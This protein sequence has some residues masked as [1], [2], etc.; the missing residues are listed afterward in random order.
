MMQ[1]SLNTTYDMCIKCNTCVVN[2]PVSKLSIDFAGPKHLGVEL[3]R[4]TEN[5]E[6]IYDPSIKICTLCGNCDTYCPEQVD[7]TKM[8]INSKANITNYYGLKFR[9]RLLS[10]AELIG[11][12]S[13]LFASIVNV[14]LG[15]SIIRKVMD[16]VLHIEQKRIFPKYKFSN[17]RRR[18][19]KKSSYTKRKVVYF[20]GCYTNYNAPEVADAFIEVMKLNNIE[21]II[22]KQKCCGIPSL[23]NG[24]IKKAEKY[25]QYNIN[26]FLK[27]VRKGYD[28]VITCSSCSLAFK[29]KYPSIFN[30]EGSKELSEKVYDGF[31]YLM[32]LYQLGE[33]N[34]N[35]LD[36]KEKASYYTP[37]HIKSQGIGTPAIDILNLIPNYEIND[38][39]AEC[40]G[41]CGTFGFKK[42]YFDLSINMGKSVQKE[43]NDSNT[44]Y[45]VTEC[46]MCKNQINQLTNAQVMHPMQVLADSYNKAELYSDGVLTP[47]EF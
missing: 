10:N 11:K 16:K 5:Q 27:Y 36:T 37:C 26:N 25:A 28:V 32:M 43:V 46:G 19:R 1:N 45:V 4:L 29:E 6:Y 34:T 7:I 33:L 38:L 42:E 18:Y 31:E 13:S 23:A 14:S 24:R 15:N 44:D 47:P 12:I 41:Q 39:A 8:L 9:D 2:C 40:C 3:R 20:I 30:I 21:V 17:L 35:F 22:P